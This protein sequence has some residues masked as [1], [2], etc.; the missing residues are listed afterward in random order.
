M[1]EHVEDLS[2]R[3]A[4][5]DMQEAQGQPWALWRA[6]HG[7]MVAPQRQQRAAPID[8]PRRRLRRLPRLIARGLAETAAVRAGAALLTHGV[9]PR[10]Q[11]SR[12]EVVVARLPTRLDGLRVLQVSDLH[13]HA[14][15]QPARQIPAL[16]AAVPHD[17]VCY[18]GDFI[19]SD[20]DLQRLTQFLA[21]MPR[22]APAYAVL[23][24][25]DYSPYGRGEGGNDVQRLRATLRAA[26]IRVLSNEALPL[27]EGGLYVAGVDDPATERDDLAFTLAQ[28]PAAACCLLLAH[29]PDVVLR[30]GARRPAVIL[31]GHTHG[32]Q[33]RLPLV[34]ALLTQSKV[35]RR[36][37][38]GLHSYRGMQLFVSRG[39]GYSGLDIRIGC[40]P[41]VALLTLRAPILASRRY[42]FPRPRDGEGAL[43]APAG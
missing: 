41:E 30:P 25:H 32:G 18:T 39:V 42:R 38:M 35:P 9:A 1:L 4:T 17:L 7:Q 22:S 19:D 2:L 8:P 14:G 23:G 10:V 16:I 37:A 11:L 20:D 31:A 36:L 27:Y 33:I 15:S 40:P 13:L 43:L 28:V 29:S 5:H 6:D 34:G 21:L 24:N 3:N 26:G 12:H